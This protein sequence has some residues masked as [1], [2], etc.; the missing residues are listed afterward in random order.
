MRA[1]SLWRRANL[2]H[3]ICVFDGGNS[4]EGARNVFSGSL[5]PK[6]VFFKRCV[7]DGSMARQSSR[8]TWGGSIE[9][10]AFLMGLSHGG[11]KA[12]AVAAKVVLRATVA[13]PAEQSQLCVTHELECVCVRIGMKVSPRLVLCWFLVE[14]GVSFCPVFC[15]GFQFSSAS[16]S[17]GSWTSA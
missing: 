9:S 11:F 13:G 16:L 4:L 7:F 8:T 17:A 1:R 10:K 5:A 12:V 6:R 15:R 2:T 3:D 14:F